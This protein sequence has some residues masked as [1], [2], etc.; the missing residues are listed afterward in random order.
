MFQA[1]TPRRFLWLVLPAIMLAGS[2]ALLHLLHADDSLLPSRE[3]WLSGFHG[4]PDPP[5]PLVLE[6]AYPK[7]SFKGPTSLHRIPNDDRFIVLEHWSKIYSFED[8][9]QVDS[10]DLCADLAADRPPES[11]TVAGDKHRIEL[12]SLAFHPDFADNRW[13][14]LAYIVHGA[15]K[16]ITHLSRFELS[17]TQPPQLLV[18]TELEIL[19]CLGGGHNGCTLLF[20]HQGYLYM[21]IGDLTNPSPPDTLET[22]QDISDLYSSIL[23]IDIDHPADGK[24]YSIPPDNPFVDLPEAR[25]EVFAYGLRNPFRMSF[26]PP[27]GDLWVGDVG[28]EAW[29]M[30]Y[31]VVSG[32]NYGWAIKEGPGDVKSQPIGPTPI[33]PPDIALSHAEAASVTGGVVYRGK[34]L[35][36]IK[37]KYIFGD[38]ITRKFWAAEF[39]H[40]KTIRVEEI[41]VGT[42]KPSCF[43]TDRQGELLIADFTDDA[44]DSGIYRFVTN[45]AT[46]LASADSSIPTFPRLLSETG[47]FADTADHL[48]APGV[49]EYSLN[50][51]MWMN[52]ASQVNL[53]AIPGTGTAV[54]HEHP[55]KMF[56]WFKT[57]VTFPNGSVLAKTYSLPT[58]DDPG[59]AER[60]IETQIALKDELGEWQY[61]TYRWN[62][63]NT[64]AELVPRSGESEKLRVPD[65]RVA[66]GERELNW[67]F[68]SRTQCRIC[69][70]PWAGETLGFIEQQLRRPKQQHDSWRTLLDAGI[71]RTSH[72]FTPQLVDRLSDG[73]QIEPPPSGNL[74]ESEESS[75]ASLREHELADR[76]SWP[77]IGAMAVVSDASEPLEDRARAY[78]HANCAHCHLSGGSASTT[79]DVTFPKTL[80]ET[81]LV[82]ALPMRGSM[83]LSDARLIAAGD[84]SRSVVWVRMAKSGS[85]HM[86]HMGATIVDAEGVRLLSAWI[87]QLAPDADRRAWLETVC[88]TSPVEDRSQRLEAAQA[89]MQSL[90]GSILLATALEENRVPTQLIEAIVELSQSQEPTIRELI[91]PFGAPHQY[92]QRLGTD[93][94][95]A[96]VL[97]LQGDREAGRQ[98]FIAG[99]GECAKCHRVADAISNELATEVGPDLSRAQ[100]KWKTR[101]SLL[102]QIMHPSLEIDAAYRS[103]TVVDSDGKVLAGRVLAR[104]ERWLTL[105]DAQ[106][107]DLMVEN[108]EI[109]SERYSPVST[110]P[111]QVLAPLTA[112]QAANLLEFLMTA[113]E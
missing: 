113:A 40:E 91:E 33:R 88:R 43:E 110:M 112:Q 22:G 6:R 7:L 83:G 87:Q 77:A 111:E 73:K 58:I 106:G 25:P 50:A 96:E 47:L 48:P 62:A 34:R 1:V 11:A 16:P 32:G 13:V 80:S 64:D 29:E 92:I 86:P 54:F 67:Q 68:G 69:H 84:L 39:D 103:L 60:R 94:D 76:S 19:T 46:K 17:D 21:S 38:W 95:P 61:Y 18:D 65:R 72:R 102:T 28:W 53:L 3:S 59:I 26:D 85:G 44:Q 66:G 36:E 20:D 57:Y 37:G 15:E 10:A 9:E 97:S 70:T 93:F 90:E 45:P 81:K 108:S 31:R 82:D 109:E 4:S 35:P 23:R 74:A 101:E 52:G 104:D 8:R 75:A 99:V 55:Q 51:P 56:D 49:V 42:V 30:V 24:N 2:T 78:L 107:K 105:R 89:L 14:F 5:L 27:T 79:F 98:L 71:V 63:E 12:Y 41:A 100:E